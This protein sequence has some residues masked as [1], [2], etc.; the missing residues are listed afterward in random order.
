MK[1][2][3]V[4]L[5]GLALCASM[6]AFAQKP[7]EEGA[8][9]VYDFVPHFY[10]QG[11][12]GGQY[13]LGE[14]SFGKLLS[15]NAQLGIGYQFNPVFGLRLSANAWQSKGG[16]D[17][18]ANNTTYKWKYNYVAPQLDLTFNLSN[19]LC[20]FNPKRVFNLS[21]LIGG[22]AN[23]AWNND[24]AHDVDAAVRAA[25]KVGDSYA[26]QNLQYL[27]DGTK[28]RGFGHAALAGDFRVSDRVALGLEVGAN[29]LSDHYNSKK[30][31]NPD[32]YFNALAGIKVNLGKSYNKR[33][34]PAP[35][36][37]VVE[38]VVEKYVDKPAPAEEKHDQMQRNVYYTIAKT[39]VDVAQEKKVQDIADFLNEHKD[40]KVS[41]TGYADAG[42][43][44]AN[45][46][47]KLAKERA[48]K[49]AKMLKGYG[50]DESRISVDSK[51]D[52]VQPFSENDRNRVVI[53]VA[54]Y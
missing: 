48:E 51:G 7:A 17:L 14:I 46:N 53:A 54:K 22:G 32:W 28:V 34:I 25:T 37:Q 47:A 5:S 39:D 12:I 10:I 23:I 19:L 43:G 50:I 2:Y 29:V 15:P 3:K 36:P 38:R 1:L 8:K 24:E 42:T 4:L 27:W 49:V 20:G 41:V 35:A 31:G 18:A 26:G 9:T 6:T 30:A 52:T 45:I 11:Q 44:N 16:W 21:F 13:T 33:E 40:A